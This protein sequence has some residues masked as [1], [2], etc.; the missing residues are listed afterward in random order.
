MTTEGLQPLNFKGSLV[1]TRNS[2]ELFSLLETLTVELGHLEQEQTDLGSLRTVSQ[3]LISSRLMKN[4][5]AGIRTLVACC[6]MEVL[7]IHA[8]DAPYSIEMLKVSAHPSMSDSSPTKFPEPGSTRYRWCS[9][10]PEKK[11]K[12]WFCFAE[13]S[14]LDFEYSEV[15]DELDPNS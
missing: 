15:L 7:R 9:S 3:E 14:I 6:L 2:D 10:F 8:P 1:Q 11:Q 13:A 4:K 5:N 12:R